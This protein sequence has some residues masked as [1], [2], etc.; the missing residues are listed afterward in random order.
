LFVDETLEKVDR[1]FLLHFGAAKAFFATTDDESVG[2]F[3][4]SVDG[5]S[6]L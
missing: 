2:E 6:E 4:F 3:R 1:L 5:A